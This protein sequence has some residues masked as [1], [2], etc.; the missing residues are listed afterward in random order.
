MHKPG[1]TSG[2]Q[3]ELQQARQTLQIL[4]VYLLEQWYIYH[5]LPQT[6]VRYVWIAS[7]EGVVCKQCLHGVPHADKLRLA[8]VQTYLLDCAL[9]LTA[10]YLHSLLCDKFKYLVA[11][12]HST[13]TGTALVCRISHLPALFPLFRLLL[14]PCMLTH[15]GHV[16]NDLTAY[17]QW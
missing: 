12:Q 3:A 14:I 9:A 11:K 10:P 8:W 16:Q 1:V 5:I 6:D 17:T 2:Q 15:T 13:N 7:C 4:V